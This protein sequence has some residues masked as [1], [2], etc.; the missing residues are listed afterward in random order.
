MPQISTSQFHNQ[1]SED[2]QKF[3][4]RKRIKES[5]RYEKPRRFVDLGSIQVAA[6]SYS[7]KGRIQVS[8][9][10]ELGDRLDQHIRD[11][12]LDHTIDLGYREITRRHE[13]S[14]MHNIVQPSK[15][16]NREAIPK[17]MNKSRANVTALLQRMKNNDSVR[18][19]LV[20]NL[21]NSKYF[22]S[23]PSS[24]CRTKKC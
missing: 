17:G 18:S 5:R 22:V 16:E 11:S 15:S 13:R 6:G 19:K 9:R 1:A 8:P 24:P 2:I 7:P 3:L 12:H 10:K 20:Q 14:R 4:Q 21:N 23:L